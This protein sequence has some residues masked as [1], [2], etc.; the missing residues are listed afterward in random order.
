CSESHQTFRIHCFI[1]ILPIPRFIE[2]TSSFGDIPRSST[3][4]TTSL[5]HRT[6]A[7]DR[8]SDALDQRVSSPP[9]TITPPPSPL[10]PPL[11]LPHPIN[12]R[13]RRVDEEALA[14][15]A[16]ALHKTTPTSA[17]RSTPPAREEE[18]C[19]CVNTSRLRFF[20]N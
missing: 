11:P 16:I 2:H 4:T 15:A 9:T 3:A 13:T 1:Y 20:T 17:S 8:S 14:L 12:H 6:D 10:P 5:G 18:G 7:P 19:G